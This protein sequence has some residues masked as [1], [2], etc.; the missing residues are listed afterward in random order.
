MIPSHINHYSELVHEI[1]SYCPPKPNKPLL[2][3]K[4]DTEPALLEEVHA[5]IARGD[6]Q[7]AVDLLVTRAD[8]DPSISRFYVNDWA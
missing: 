8:L 7:A 2:D 3:E 1:Q 5:A 4:L 6:K